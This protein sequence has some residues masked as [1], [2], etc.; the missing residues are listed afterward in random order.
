MKLDVASCGFVVIAVGNIDGITT[1]YMYAVD[2]AGEYGYFLV[3]VEVYQDCDCACITG[4][5]SSGSVLDT[6]SKVSP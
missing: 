3:E 6:F 2:E 1:L 4:R 5:S